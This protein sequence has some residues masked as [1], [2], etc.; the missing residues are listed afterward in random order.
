[1]PEK[2]GRGKGGHARAI[3]RTK[4]AARH[5]KRGGK[6]MSLARYEAIHRAAWRKSS[7]NVVGHSLGFYVDRL[8]RGLFFAFVKYGDGEWRGIFG[9][10]RRAGEQKLGNSLL[11]KYLRES[12]GQHY[13]KE[14]YFLAIQSV[15]YLKKRR[16]LGQIEKWTRANAPHSQ[17]HDGEIFTKASRWGGLAPFVTE[18]RK[19]QV[20]V[21]GPR[22]LGKLD[23]CDKHIVVPG[24]N[25]FSAFEKIL[26]MAQR[27][28]EE[29]VMLFS[30][31]P[32]AKILIHKLW[33]QAKRCFMIDT[34]SLWDVYCGKRSRGYHRSITSELIERNFG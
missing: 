25:C 12:V 14:R 9:S 27:N 19:H 30:A 33:P 11:R 32:T 5:G 18:L 1:M 6:L 34:G 22:H 15:P 16:L 23:F 21:V 20:V 3:K 2:K 24:R 13:G 8:R 29:V 4:Q 17:W 10:G 28:C 31:G 7:L 26:E